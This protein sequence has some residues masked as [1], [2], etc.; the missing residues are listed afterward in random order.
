MTILFNRTKPSVPIAVS[1]F[2][3]ANAGDLW[4]CFVLIYGFIMSLSRVC[5]VEVI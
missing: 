4:Y 3:Y 1:I 2:T 5:I